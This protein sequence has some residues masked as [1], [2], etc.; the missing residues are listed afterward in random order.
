[1]TETFT[2]LICAHL[3][4]DFAFQSNGMAQDKARRRPAAL[5]AHLAI[6]A[7]LSALVLAQ[8]SREGLIALALVVIA[9]LVIDLAKSYA[10]PTLTAFVLDQTAHL[11]ATV[12]IAALFPTLWA[13]SFWAGQV[14]LPGALT[15]I[16]GAVL[17]VRAGGF[18]VGLLMA[19]FGADAPPE[20]LP[21]GGRLI[22]QLE[23]GV[24]FLLVLAGQPSAIGFLIA[25]KSI[26]RFEAVSK[27]GANP[28]SEYVIIGTLASFGW[29]LATTYA[30]QALL[31]ALPPLGILPV[32]N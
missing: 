32:P 25:A 1:M 16:A 12:A 9:H 15:L 23:R 18:A 31:N 13:Q 2:L 30:T 27:G 19:R 11:A 28:K 22:G 5:A 8:L 29:A 17:T 24:I 26:L 3:L 4:T 7:A 10:R 6:L 14:W 21:E 20:G